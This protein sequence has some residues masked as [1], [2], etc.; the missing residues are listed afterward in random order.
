M[1]FGKHRGMTIEEIIKLDPGYILWMHDEKIALIDD[2]VLSYAE[3]A[4]I[5]ERLSEAM[6][7]EFRG[8]RYWDFI[9]DD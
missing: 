5:D 6:D 1:Q 8:M 3:E 2:T 9:G 7:S 4:D